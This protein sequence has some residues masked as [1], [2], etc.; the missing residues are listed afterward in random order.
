MPWLWN[1][2]REVSW[3]DCRSPVMH[4]FPGGFIGSSSGKG[5]PDSYYSILTRTIILFF[6]VFFGNN[7]RFTEDLQTQYGEFLHTLQP[8]L[9][10]LLQSFTVS[11]P[12]LVF[13]TLTVLKS[14]CHMF[15]RMSFNLGFP[16]IR[17]K[18]WIWRRA[19]HGWSVH[20]IASFQGSICYREEQKSNY[21]LGLF[22]LL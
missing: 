12:F 20:L 21:M 10:A 18:F 3:G 13:V 22:L 2:L 11:W 14:A 6:K 8:C 4:W 5:E 16:I 15:C 1:S 9:L 7:F 19:Q 17:L